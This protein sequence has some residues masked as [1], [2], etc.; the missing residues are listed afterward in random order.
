VGPSFL[1][2]SMRWLLRVVGVRGMMFMLVIQRERREHK[3]VSMESTLHSW[4]TNTNRTIERVNQPIQPFIQTISCS[5]TGRLDVPGSFHR[6]QPKLVCYFNDTHGTCVVLCVRVVCVVLCVLVLCVL[7][8]ECCVVCV[9][10][11]VLCCVLVLC[12][13]CCV[14]CVVCVVLCVLCC[15]LVLCVL[16]LCVLCCVCCVVS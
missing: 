14:C 13:L 3:K 1:R 12:V 15:V 11:C 5:G 6:V 8:C 9:V 16:V 10:L 4:S 2:W 7:C